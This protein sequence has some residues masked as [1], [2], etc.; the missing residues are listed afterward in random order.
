LLKLAKIS[1][2]ITL[3]WLGTILTSFPVLSAERIT[4]LLPPFSRTLEISSLEKFA[5]NGVIDANLRQ[6][7]GGTTP[8]QQAEFRQALTTNKEISPVLLSRFFN[9]QMGEDILTLLGALITIQGDI[10]GKFALRSALIKSAFEPGGVTILS[11]LRNLPTNMQIDLNRVIS[12][13]RAIDLVLKATTL[14][15][16]KVAQLSLEE[17]K[18]VGEINFAAMTNPQ[19]LGSLQVEQIRLDL[20]DSARQRELY[21]I[22]VKPKGQLTEKTPVIVFSH[23]LASRPEDFVRQAEHWASYGY[24]VA[25]PQHPGSD[26]IQVQ[27]LINGLSRQVFDTNEFVNRPLDV[28][29]VIDELLRRNTT[30][31][32]GKLDLENVGVGGHSFG[33]YTALAVGG[34]TIDFEN[35][36]NDCQRRLAFLNVSL[37]L[38]CRALDLSRQEY[39]FRD[40]RVKAIFAVNPFNRS[41]FGAKGLGKIEIPTFLAAGTYD[42]ATP[43]I[44]EQVRSFP[45]LNTQDKYLALI[46]GQAHVDFSVLDA[47]INEVLESVADLTLPAPYVI[48]GYAHSLSL[49]FFEVYIRKNPTYKP[50]LQAAYSQYISQGQDFKCFLITRAS[51][52]A[53]D[54]LI[55]D[56]IAQNVR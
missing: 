42:P 54:K 12:L 34:A 30:E 24:L 47:G 39:N 8:Q 51:S 37:L 41:I 29:F 5:K 33:G 9:T 14:F 26:T 38:Q 31:F 46:E 3:G 52:K 2:S 7:I 49:A 6:Y 55:E 40:P 56:F 27:N 50:F 15:T 11:L 43:A 13:A 45:L 53:L 19:Q 1:R 23:G 21:L 10:N 28:S 25:M 17:A 18:N 16:E 35:L 44:F 20:T 22:I 36:K 48:D 32:Q 4:F